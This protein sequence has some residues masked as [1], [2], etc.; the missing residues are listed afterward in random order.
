MI[1]RRGSSFATAL[2]VLLFVAAVALLPFFVDDFQASQYAYVGIYFIAICGL[3][4]LTGY[5]GQIS[6]GH[7]AFMAVGGYTTA[8]LAA[9]AGFPYWTTI[10][11]A[12]IVAGAAGLLLAIPALRLSGLY[13]ALA[14]FGLAL[15]APALIKEFPDLTGG[16]TGLSFDL[17]SAP[18]WTGLTTNDWFY[19]LSWTIALVLLA[20]AWLLL[21]G[22][23]GR[24]FRAVRDSEVAAVSFGIHLPTYKTL[25]FSVSAFYAGVA[26]ALFAVVNLSYVSPET[27][28]LAPL[29]LPRRGHGRGRA[30]D[31]VGHR[32]R[33][34]AH[35]VA[36]RADVRGGHG[37]ADGHRRV[38]G[39]SAAFDARSER[40][41]HRRL[42][43]RRGARRR[44]DPAAQGRRRAP[45][46]RRYR[47]GRPPVH[48]LSPGMRRP[49]LIAFAALLVAAGTALAGSTADPGLTDSTILIGGTA[50]ISGEASAAAAV[51][52]GADAYF[53]SVNDAGG[54]NKRKI[55]YKFVDDG[56]DPART[57]QAVRQLVQQDQVF[58]LFQTLGTN[59]NLAVRDF[60]N[61]SGVPHLFVASGA[62]TWGADY[63]KYPWTIGFIPSYVLEGRVYGRYIAKSFP[64]LKLGVL[65]Q[66][67]AYGKDLV[68]GLKKGLGAKQKQIVS[69]VGYDPTAASV[70][71]QVA[72]IKASKANAFL[73]FAFGK[74]SVQAGIEAAKLGWKPKLVIVNAVAASANL[75]G[76]GD[77][78]GAKS[79]NKG[80]VSIV[81][82][83]D[84]TD[85][86]WAKDPGLALAPEDP[87]EVR[88][89]REPEGR[90]LRGGDRHR[91]VDG[92]RAQTGGPES[93]PRVRPESRKVAE[94]DEAPARGSRHRRQDVGHRRLP[95]G[96][97]RAPA[98]GYGQ[99]QGF[100]A[101]GDVR[102]PARRD[103]VALPALQELERARVLAQ[104]D[105]LVQ[106]RRLRAGDRVDDAA[107]RSLFLQ[108]VERE[109]AYG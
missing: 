36:R 42:R 71:S 60:L 53:K 104:A 35:R 80:A 19:Y 6:L 16:S 93:H 64:T 14:T 38:G 88:A 92:G 107:R 85:P 56:Y 81:F 27:F 45:A 58:A 46:A 7:G 89:E 28:A 75:M 87:Q 109:Q 32:V 48:S 41:R 39:P 95:H 1:P 91:H 24:S 103:G 40:H 67:D 101:L 34:A 12:G 102:P 68:A 13:L 66:D 52:R 26:G 82:F 11:L 20:A 10:P 23:T 105:R 29:H 61:Q 37:V 84:P 2:A 4:I 25:A 72:Q 78:A 90:L 55:T 49:V 30:R 100:W 99:G 73:I 18:S 70:A 3:N 97:G 63:K 108:P 59:N 65:Y 54:I 83:K 79:I 77:L 51:A 106:R 22:R 74:F 76:L 57:V 43:L 96:A 44:D 47:S 94:P 33:R 31:A 15:A 62:N 9:K 5:T 98:V 17:V 21:R 50:P 86:K 69:L 8:I